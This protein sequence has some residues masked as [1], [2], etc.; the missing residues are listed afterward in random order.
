MRPVQCF[1]SGDRSSRRWATYSGFGLAVL[2]LLLVV[3]CGPDDPNIGN[4]DTGGGSGSDAAD[5]GDTGGGGDDTDGMGEEGVGDGT[6]GGGEAAGDGTGGDTE[7]DGVSDDCTPGENR[8]TAEGKSQTCVPGPN[9]TG[10][11]GQASECESDEFCLNG[12]CE[13]ESDHPCRGE[14]TCSPNANCTPD[15]QASDGYVCECHGNFVDYQGDGSICFPDYFTAIQPGTFQM[16][17][18]SGESD[19]GDDETQH[20]VEISHALA[21]QTY[22]TVQAD[23]GAVFPGNTIPWDETS[24]CTQTVCPLFNV[25]WWDAVKF[26]NGLSE[27]HGLDTCY[28]LQGCSGT[29]GDDFSCSGVNFEGLSCDGWRLP[30]EA[31]WEFLARAGTS[32][33]THGG[34]ASAETLKTIAWFQANSEGQAHE[35][36]AKESNAWGINDVSGN[37]AEWVWDWYGSYDSGSQT[38][39]T[40]PDSGSER[41]VRGGHWDSG[42][43]ACRSAARAKASPDTRNEKTGFRLVRTLPAK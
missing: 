25:S 4:D 10:R 32:T 19:R 36:G 22:E 39:P 9:N 17:S 42:T 43:A 37:V 34:D 2:A 38:D 30:T 11:W 18:P 35:W 8:C 27:S 31:E 16:G 41:V 28:E 1:S 3:A 23:W 33:P 40:G 6:G 26:A 29:P 15:E 7:G 20:E 24:N 21:V 13:K 5:A 14:T 12:L